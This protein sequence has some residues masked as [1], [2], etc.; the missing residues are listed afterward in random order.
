ML[1]FLLNVAGQ[2]KKFKKSGTK[3]LDKNYVKSK[4]RKTYLR[5]KRA[6]KPPLNGN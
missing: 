3:N 2:D 1:T 4:T 6:P 5:D